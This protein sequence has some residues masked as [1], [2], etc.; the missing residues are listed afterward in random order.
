MTNRV[1][2]LQTVADI[3]RGGIHE[4]DKCEQQQGGHEHHRFPGLG[5]SRLE[6]DIEDVETQMHETALQMNEGEEAVNRQS[7][8]ELDDTH[9]H[10]RCD[11]ARPTRHCQNQPGH[12]PRQRLGQHDMPDRLPLRRTAGERTFAH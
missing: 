1:L 12:D 5:V 7:G 8:R 11:F 2:P 9:Q 6:A 4:D 3:D 10:E